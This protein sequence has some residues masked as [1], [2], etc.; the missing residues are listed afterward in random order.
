[1]CETRE[2]SEKSERSEDKGVKGETCERCETCAKGGTGE[3]DD[4]TR[5]PELRVALFPL[6]PPVSL[7][8]GMC[9]GGGNA[10]V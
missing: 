8:A 3:M 6:V 5:F 1:M 10:H 9:D 4:G 2:T 7:E